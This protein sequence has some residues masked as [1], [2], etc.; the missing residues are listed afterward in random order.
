MSN[1]SKSNRRYPE[2]AT[3]RGSIVFLT[4]GVFVVLALVAL[5]VWLIS[6]PQLVRPE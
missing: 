3:G 5:L 6:N 4:L 1:R 2:S